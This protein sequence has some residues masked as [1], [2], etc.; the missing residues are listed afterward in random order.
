MLRD[1][2]FDKIA[3]C[4]VNY[5]NCDINILKL[6]YMDFGVEW[7]VPYHKHTYFEIHYIIDGDAYT[8]FKDEENHYVKGDFYVMKP[9]VIHAHYQK[10]GTKHLGFAMS[11]EFANA[12]IASNIYKRLYDISNKVRHDNGNVLEQIEFI[13]NAIDNDKPLEIIKL[14]FCKMLYL[15]SHV[16]GIEPQKVVGKDFK[17]NLID[18]A[19]VFMNE[20]I[21]NNLTAVEI[22]NAIHISYAHLNRLVKEHLGVSVKK[23]YRDMKIKKAEEL[24][25]YTKMSIDEI[26]HECGFINT[27]YFYDIFKRYYDMTPSE[28][29]KKHETI[30]YTIK[31]E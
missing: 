5:D 24:L 28:Y 19:L 21:Q 6:D 29:R 10:E 17:T 27:T 8:K 22:A 9:G 2:S 18:Q 11:W 23:V 4:A 20:N 30:L 26:A 25:S 14:E 1:T 13:A 3:Y 31:T 16:E 12:N 15:I 7:N